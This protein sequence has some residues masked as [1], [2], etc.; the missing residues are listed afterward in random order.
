MIDH[1]SRF[2]EPYA[3][4]D[5]EARTFAR[6]LL[7]WIGRYG[8]PSELLSDQGTNFVNLIIDEICRINGIEKT[9]K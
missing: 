6:C 4:P 8:A 2:I 7:D 5:L 3:V 9:L 1:F